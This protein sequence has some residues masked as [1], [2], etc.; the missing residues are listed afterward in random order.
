MHDLI[1]AFAYRIPA[2][3]RP[4]R[5]RAHVREDRDGGGRGQGSTTVSQF[6]RY[7]VR[8]NTPMTE[9]LASIEEGH[10]PARL[11]GHVKRLLESGFVWEDGCLL[12]SDMATADHPDRS[13]YPDLTG[14]EALVNRFRIEQP[15]ASE[16]ELAALGLAGVNQLRDELLAL[17][18]SGL[19][20]IV[21]SLDSGAPNVFVRFHRVRPGESLL[22][23]DLEGYEEP[24]LVMDVERTLSVMV[25]A[26][27]SRLAT[28]DPRTASLFYAIEGGIPNPRSPKVTSTVLRC[29]AAGQTV[30]RSNS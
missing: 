13:H 2:L 9:L 4:T 17:D 5:L 8:Q 22:A 7:T 25:R 15:H 3:A 23:E 12:L 1:Y 18:G 21:M 19:C 30:D 26:S 11:P 20:R 14:Y 24:V 6:D 16:V 29:Q 10:E 27:T 28:F